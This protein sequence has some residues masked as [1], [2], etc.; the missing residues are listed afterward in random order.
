MLMWGIIRSGLRDG[1]WGGDDARQKIKRFLLRP[2]FTESLRCK[3]YCR[4]SF[5]SLKSDA[6]RWST[7]TYLSSS[8]NQRNPEKGPYMRQDVADHDYC[9]SHAIHSLPMQD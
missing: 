7:E 3:L 1:L 9:D 2:V 6:V 5:L 4:S 8:R